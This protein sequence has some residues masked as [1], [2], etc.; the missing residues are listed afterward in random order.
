MKAAD[1]VVLNKGK[2]VFVV[3]EAGLM[4]VLTVVEDH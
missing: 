3:D 1:M 4:D 2:V